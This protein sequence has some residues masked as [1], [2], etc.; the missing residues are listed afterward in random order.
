MDT[1]HVPLARHMIMH[2]AP[3]SVRAAGGRWLSLGGA[4]MHRQHE[5][6]HYPAL[7]QFIDATQTS[8]DKIRTLFSGISLFL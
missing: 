7:L 3:I 6:S 1:K 8:Y 4:A 2:Y 5:A